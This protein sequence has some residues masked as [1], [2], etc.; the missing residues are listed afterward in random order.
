[1]EGW[2]NRILHNTAMES[3]ISVADTGVNNRLEKNTVTDTLYAFS[4]EGEGAKL[5]RNMAENSGSAGFYLADTSF[6]AKLTGNKA[7]NG[8]F[9]N[10]GFLI[11][12]DHTVLRKNTATNNGTGIFIESDKNNKITG[13]TALSNGLDLRE[14]TSGCGTNVWQKNAFVTKSQVCIQ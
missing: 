13:N 6:G 5:T 12:G 9:N 3:D 14:A 10:F 11:N 7:L 8:P 4:D 1:V 2:D